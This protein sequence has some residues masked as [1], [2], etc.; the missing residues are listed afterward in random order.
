MITPNS[1]EALTQRTETIRP[2]RADVLVKIR[3]ARKAIGGSSPDLAEIERQAT[4]FYDALEAISNE[5]RALLKDTDLSD[6]G[7][8]NRAHNSIAALH[9]QYREASA[10]TG[11]T[12]N[13]K[14]PN[15]TP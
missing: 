11:T 7:K 3:A 5:F 13:H 6:Q 2:L 15:T 9:E 8:A 10:A 14:R 1:V 4:R 12:S